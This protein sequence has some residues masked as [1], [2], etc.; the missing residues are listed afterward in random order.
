MVLRIL[1]KFDIKNQKKSQIKIQ[2]H[3]ITYTRTHLISF[4]PRQ[5]KKRR[6]KK[7]YTT[8]RIK[9]VSI[10]EQISISV[11]NND[12]RVRAS[13]SSNAAFILFLSL[14][15]SFFFVVVVGWSF[16]HLFALFRPKK[17]KKKKL[18]RRSLNCNGLEIEQI[19]SNW[20][21]ECATATGQHYSLYANFA[22][23]SSFDESQSIRYEV[24]C[25]AIL[26]GADSNFTALLYIHSLT[27]SRVL[28]HFVFEREHTLEIQA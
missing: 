22:S 19:N 5:K 27:R 9:F 17:R 4:G 1:L 3:E 21:I 15:D 8:D 26:I 13:M 18:F 20:K 16:S 11:R 6:R 14:R 25:V 2:Q 24:Q 28:H 12:K 23:S 7:K 10:C